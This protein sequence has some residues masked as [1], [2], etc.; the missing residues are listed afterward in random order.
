MGLFGIKTKRDR[1]EEEYFKYKVN[2]QLNMSQDFE[3]KVD[4]VFTIMGCGTLVTGVIT[5][6]M[7]RVGEKA[8][9]Q[10]RDGTVLDT[11][12]IRI[13]IFTKARR[14]LE[15]AYA[16]EQAGIGLRYL[17]KDQVI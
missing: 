13:D 6:G 4:E 16:N 2:P 7:C 10:K 15:V 1:M 5:S 9:L 12:I 11:G 17:T 8:I 3:M 14:N